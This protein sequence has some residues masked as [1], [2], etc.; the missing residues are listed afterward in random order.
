[1]GV[2]VVPEVTP[3]ALKP[4]PETVTLEML[5]LEFPVF[6]KV[7]LEE[8]LPPTFTLPKLRLVGFTPSR[9]VAAAPVPL[10]AIVSGEPGALLVMETLPVALPVA[11]G[12]NCPLKVVLCPAASVSGTDKPVMLKPVPEALAAEIVTLAVPELLNVKVCAPLLPTSIFP[13]LKLEGLAVSVPCTPVPLKVIVAG[14]FVALL[15]TLTLPVTL[16]VEA[17]AKATLRVTV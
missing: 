12:A 8:P 17:G 15:A 4:A 6:V 16:P 5:T 2:K 1:L 7:T 11:E 10:R 3:L 9:K 14:E 13:K